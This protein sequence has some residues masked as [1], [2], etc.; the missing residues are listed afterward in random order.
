MKLLIA[1][2][3]DDKRVII[4]YRNIIAIEEFTPSFTTILVSGN[5]H[6]L[7]KGKFAGYAKLLDDNLA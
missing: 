7:L 1:K 5:N 6:Y 3:S 4:P 2:N